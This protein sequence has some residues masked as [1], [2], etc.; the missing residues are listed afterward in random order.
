MGAEAARSAGGRLDQD[1]DV[2]VGQ[3]HVAGRLR[4]LPVHLG[5][6]DA[7]LVD[8]GAGVVGAEA[9][10][11]AA[12]LVG[13]ADLHQGDVAGDRAVGDELGVLRDVARNDVHRAGLDQAPVGADAAHAVR[14]MP[15]TAPGWKVSENIARE[16]G[17][18]RRRARRAGARALR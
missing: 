10:A 12:V 2:G 14:A 7:G 3:G 6:D 17:A 4:H 5:D 18:Q 11:V 13:R 9:E 1:V 15:S 16:E 8:G